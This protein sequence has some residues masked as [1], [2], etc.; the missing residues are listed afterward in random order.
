MN[1]AP[2]LLVASPTCKLK[3]EPEQAQIRVS[4]EDSCTVHGDLTESDIQMESLPD[5]AATEQVDGPDSHPSGNKTVEH[6]ST[7][8][9]CSYLNRCENGIDVDTASS[10]LF[11][12]VKGLSKGN[13]FPHSSC[14]NVIV[15]LNED[16][17]YSTKRLRERPDEKF[18]SSKDMEENKSVQRSSNSLTCLQQLSEAASSKIESGEK[19]GDRRSVLIDE[20]SSDDFEVSHVQHTQPT[21]PKVTQ[22]ASQEE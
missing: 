10:L 20:D 6:F 22:N 2:S 19:R 15:T 3:S 4:T 8:G 14:N 5:G 1:S 7:E 16:V 17:D 11:T 9:T 18:H 12:K 13:E 21:R